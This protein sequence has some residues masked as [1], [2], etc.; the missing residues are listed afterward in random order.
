MTRSRRERIPGPRKDSQDNVPP[1]SAENLFPRSL[2][3]GAVSGHEGAISKV[4]AL[5]AQNYQIMYALTICCC[6]P[7]S[8]RASVTR[9]P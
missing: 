6:S 5:R 7:K 4:S 3:G 1:S 8:P 2:E 9:S